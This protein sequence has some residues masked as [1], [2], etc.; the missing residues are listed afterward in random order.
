MKLD[1]IKEKYPEMCAEIFA[2]AAAAEGDN[3]NLHV[4]LT[5]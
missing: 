2:S 5:P 1:T 4:M 3:N